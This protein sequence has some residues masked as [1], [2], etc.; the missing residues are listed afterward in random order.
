MEYLNDNIYTLLIKV[1]IK[2]KKERK[3]KIYNIYNLF[4]VLY[5]LINS[6]FTFLIIKHILNIDKKH[7]LL[8][9]FNFY[10]FN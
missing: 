8:N 10:Y 1:K 4:S 6:F 7:I 9:D 2:T 5:I 3:I